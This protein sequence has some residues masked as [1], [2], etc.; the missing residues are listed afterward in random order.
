MEQTSQIDINES[1]KSPNGGISMWLPYLAESLIQ[2]GAVGLLEQMQ[3]QLSLCEDRNEQND[4]HF[5][6]EGIKGIDQTKLER[7]VFELKEPY[8]QLL[9]LYDDSQKCNE[10]VKNAESEWF[11]TAGK[12]K[13]QLKAWERWA[14]ETE[15]A[16]RKQLRWASMVDI[17]VHWMFTGATQL[18]GSP[19]EFR[20]NREYFTSKV[21]KIKRVISD[22]YITDALPQHLIPSDFYRAIEALEEH[23]RH[24][25][26]LVSKER[27]AFKKLENL[28]KSYLSKLPLLS[29]LLWEMPETAHWALFR[30]CRPDLRTVSAA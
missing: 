2:Q 28:Q 27:Q 21:E 18:L 30:I 29:N 8:K 3:Q 5:L 26:D 15:I 6:I 7:A 22:S 1:F 16:R 14:T 25:D 11:P 10:A 24:V 4:G 19:Q 20:G 17:R 9:A 13:S 12:A 23:Q